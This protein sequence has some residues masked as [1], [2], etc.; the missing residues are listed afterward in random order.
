MDAAY[1]PESIQGLNVK[2]AIGWVRNHYTLAENPGM[3][4]S[5]LF[6]YYTTFAKAMDAFGE[7]PFVD[8]KGQKHAWR[9]ELFQAL[10]RISPT[11]RRRITMAR[12]AL[13]SR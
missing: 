13:L 5:G 12:T 10:L 2:A 4:K 9:M 8:S 11:R 7:D 1:A 3:G 6:Y